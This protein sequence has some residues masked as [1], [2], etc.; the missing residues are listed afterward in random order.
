MLP[1]EFIEKSNGVP[2]LIFCSKQY[3]FGNIATRFLPN[4]IVFIVFVPHVILDVLK[5][6]HYNINSIYIK[7]FVFFTKID[8]SMLETTYVR[9]MSQYNLIFKNM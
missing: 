7:I 8:S 2:F 3:S 9:E 5:F 4:S 1:S 6:Q